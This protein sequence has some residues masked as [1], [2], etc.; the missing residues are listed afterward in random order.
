[1]GEGGFPG[2]FQQLS[3]SFAMLM[4]T[5]SIIWLSLSF[6]GFWKN[7]K[8]N[9]FMSV[10][11]LFTVFPFFFSDLLP[12]Y[13][14]PAM[15][16]IGY[17]AASSLAIWKGE[18][19]LDRL[20]MVMSGVMLLLVAVPTV[21][22]FMTSFSDFFHYRD[23]GL[24]LAG[25]ENVLIIGKYEPEIVAYK[26]LGEM[27]SDKALDFGW[28]LLPVN[29]TGAMAQD[30]IDDYH[31]QRYLIHDGSFSALFVS[32]DVFRK[33]TNITRFDYVAVIRGIDA[34]PRGG[35]LIYNSS[36]VTVYEIDDKAG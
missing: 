12:W 8:N 23:S 7:W 24:L 16:A 14:L 30:F 9:L 5:G 34:R 35:R 32:S 31:T 36:N 26:T 25:K 33:D 18:E 28:I 11:Y 29:G 19:K 1:M 27:R 21:Y 6:A 4:M 17:F 15:P 2:L 10:W 22:L 13:Y 3:R 20:F